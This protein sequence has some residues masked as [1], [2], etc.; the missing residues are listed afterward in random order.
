MLRTTSG[1]I[2]LAALGLAVLGV[3]GL[4]AAWL[5]E[6]FRFHRN[7]ET[8]LAELSRQGIPVEAA[9]LIT[10][11]DSTVGNAAPFLK[12]AVEL[13]EQLR[14]KSG[15]EFK[16]FAPR[17]AEW[18]EKASDPE[19][20]ASIFEAW[21]DPQMRELLA[22]VESARQQPLF[23]VKR[24][25]ESPMSMDLEPVSSMLSLAQLLYARNL[26]LALEGRIEEAWQGVHT[27]LKLSDFASS[28][29]FLIS[30]LVGFSIERLA[31]DALEAILPLPAASQISNAQ[32][33]AMAADLTA[34]ESACFQNL[35]RAMDG[36]RILFGGRIFEQ[37]R[38]S[39]ITI[40]ELTESIIG[41]LPDDPDDSDFLQ[42][43]SVASYHG[44][45][46]FIMNRDQL[47]W[48]DFHIALRNHVESPLDE[49]GVFLPFDRGNLTAQIPKLAILTRLSAP[50]MDGVLPLAMTLA[51][52]I[53]LARLAIACGLHKRQHGTWPADGGELA[54]TDST[55]PV[56]D[57]FTGQPYDFRQRE[58]SLL[59]ASNARNWPDSKI[60]ANR[61]KALEW[62]LD[63]PEKSPPPVQP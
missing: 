30:V 42:Q 10:E 45:F 58:S 29:P 40:S 18:R 47:A 43:F 7:W 17:W 11:P 31:L 55:A 4:T 34:R 44:L 24:D 16:P 50:A 51:E 19:W 48:L 12:E 54:G 8:R 22:S 56:R 63:C 2:L 1:K 5:L 36:E 57:L 15:E 46:R 60:P 32:L 21:D 3:C 23:Y 33:E 53:R 59:L 27:L 28:E 25:L 35:T 39:K 9:Q 41:L 14:E 52:R 49:N 62:K 38:D 26:M 37:L 20:R 61:R 13:H 6:D